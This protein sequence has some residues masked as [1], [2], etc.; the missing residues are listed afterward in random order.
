MA[1]FYD[2]ID[3]PWRSITSLKTVSTAEIRPSNM[4]LVQ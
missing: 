2:D 3:E 1:S 4:D